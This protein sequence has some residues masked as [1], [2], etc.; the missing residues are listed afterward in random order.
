MSDEWVA[1]GSTEA[2]EQGC[3]CPVMDNNHGR[4]PPFPPNSEL[5]QGGWYMVEGCP[6]HDRRGA[7]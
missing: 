5:P 7:A 3:K 2:R 1:P 6:V 4:Y